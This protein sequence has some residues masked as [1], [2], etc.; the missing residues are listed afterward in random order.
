[1]S[2]P[3]NGKKYQLGLPADKAINSSASN[4]QNQTNSITRIY[5]VLA[6]V[7]VKLFYPKLRIWPLRVLLTENLYSGLQAISVSRQISTQCRV[8]A[9]DTC[10]CRLP[11]LLARRQLLCRSPWRRE[12]TANSTFWLGS[13]GKASKNKRFWILND[14]ECLRPW[15]SMAIE[16]RTKE[17]RPPSRSALALLRLSPNSCPFI[18]QCAMAAHVDS[19]RTLASLHCWSGRLESFQPCRQVLWSFWSS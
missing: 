3:Q 9:V 13:A 8:S 10:L 2:A 5:T 18:G 1:M 19:G 17:Q 16:P 7:V 6:T 15:H 11:E 12:K 4:L 14:F